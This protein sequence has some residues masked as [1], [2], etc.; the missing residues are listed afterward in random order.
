MPSPPEMVNSSS[1]EHSSL[2]ISTGSTSG[3]P[4][5]TAPTV[6]V[7]IDIDASMNETS[8]VQ[9]TVV[10]QITTHS[11]GSEMRIS[12]ISMNSAIAGQRRNSD[13][14]ELLVRS[15]NSPSPRRDTRDPFLDNESERSRSDRDVHPTD[16]VET[17]ALRP[18]NS[19]PLN[20]FRTWPVSRNLAATPSNCSMSRRN[21]S[22]DGDSTVYYRPI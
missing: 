21:G 12:D 6:V 16:D 14:S 4:M 17:P 7:H 20:L 2:N 3:A 9:P 1:N 5:P 13:E 10:E 11:S 19:R 18:G 22:G 15:F 8:N